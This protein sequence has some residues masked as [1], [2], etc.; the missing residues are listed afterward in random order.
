[1]PAPFLW[2]ISRLCES[3]NCL[4]TRALWELQH[5]PEQMALQILEFRAYADARRE[6]R[7]CKEGDDVRKAVERNPMVQVVI[8]IEHGI[9]EEQ[10]A[11]LQAA[12]IARAMAEDV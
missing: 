2:V 12:A 4:P 7:A 3:F 11:R 5:D 1:V 10:L 6:Y 8:D 9:A